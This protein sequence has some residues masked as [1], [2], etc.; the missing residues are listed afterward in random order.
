MK[1]E[2][3]DLAIIGGGPTGLFAAFYAS[4]RKMK[5]AVFESLP[6]LGGQPIQ[7]Y[8][9]KVI[10]DIAGFKQVTGKEFTAGLLEQLAEKD[11]SYFLGKKILSC[12]K[13]DSQLFTLTTRDDSFQAKSVLIATG[14]GSFEPR[15]LPFPELAHLD[16]QKIFYTLQ[17]PEKL[18]DKKIA[19]LGGG[20]SAVDFALA[21]LPYTTNIHL[22]HRRENFRALES[23][24]DE[25]SQSNV[26]Q[27]TPYV[28]TNIIEKEN[29]LQLHLRHVK[30]K[31][32]NILNVD[33]I[34]VAYGFINTHQQIE[35][36]GLT[37][38]DG[39]I[40]V[41][42][43]CE[44]NIPGLF[45]CGDIA[46]YDGKVEIIATGLGE[47]PTAVNNAYHL[48]YPD[49]KLQPTHSTSL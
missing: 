33:C 6:E 31:E 40:L 3:F 4:L 48:L 26:T 35:M 11:I 30:T 42:S 46:T 13:E 41:N 1:K 8:P 5:V 14:G 32:E 27:K 43:L 36:N 38:Q 10:K 22:I 28:L 18:R 16:N 49:K 34:L 37:T 39:K 44:T 45:A 9:E 47:A 23:S 7:L 20:D 19:I 12:Q 17:H 15:T 29:G 2:I 24:L 25:L 21:L